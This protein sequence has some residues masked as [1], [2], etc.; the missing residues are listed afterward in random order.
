LLSRQ[1]IGLSE[2]TPFSTAIVLSVFEKREEEE[3]GNEESFE[4]TKDT[5]QAPQ[6]NFMDPYLCF[7]LFFDR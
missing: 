7:K 6:L 4:T 5:K 1:L 3:E 2:A